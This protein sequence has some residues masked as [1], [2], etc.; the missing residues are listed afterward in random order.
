MLIIVCAAQSRAHFSPATT[1][2]LKS[3]KYLFWQAKICFS[4]AD[5]DDDND[6]V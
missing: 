2:L 1:E 3:P 6:G 5:D 4:S